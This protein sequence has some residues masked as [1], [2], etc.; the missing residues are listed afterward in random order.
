MRALNHLAI[1]PT[2][3]GQIVTISGSKSNGDRASP[4]H[5]NAPPRVRKISGDIPSP[6]PAYLFELRAA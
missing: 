3:S 6:P 5:F 1:R 2:G 4:S